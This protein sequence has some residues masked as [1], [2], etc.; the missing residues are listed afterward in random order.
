METTASNAEQEGPDP[1]MM[2]HSDADIILRGTD[3]YA[4]ISMRLTSLAC[5]RQ[6]WLQPAPFSE[7]CSLWQSQSMV[8]ADCRVSMFRKAELGSYTWSSLS[9]GIPRPKAQY[10]AC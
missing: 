6:I 2:K 1:W 10:A 3:W 7:T 4:R 5:E 8:K 9:A